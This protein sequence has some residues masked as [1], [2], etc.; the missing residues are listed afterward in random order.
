MS[1]RS[2][3]LS[4]GFLLLAGLL[5]LGLSLGILSLCRSIWG[6]KVL[7]DVEVVR[8]P[9]STI[10]SGLALSEILILW[11]LL[12]SCE[13]IIARENRTKLA[14]EEP[15]RLLLG[16]IIFA[17]WIPVLVAPVYAMLLFV[18]TDTLDHAWESVLWVGTG[19]L[20]VSVRI[21]FLSWGIKMAT[22][23]NLLQ[24]FRSSLR[25]LLAYV[26]MSLLAIASLWVTLDWSE[27]FVQLWWSRSDAGRLVALDG[28]LLAVLMWFW[29]VSPRVRDGLDVLASASTGNVRK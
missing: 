24:T 18:P 29:I 2:K 12:K 14:P 9:I 28:L 19:I 26:F 17:G 10:L 25:V 3:T 8:T 15:R 6:V 16:S 7:Y 13:I 5:G 11:L 4:F 22:G 20:F 1:L 21:R 27:L 23:L